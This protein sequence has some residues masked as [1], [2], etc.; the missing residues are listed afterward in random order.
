MEDTF[1]PS[2]EVRQKGA[3]GAVKHRG[4]TKRITRLQKAEAR[5][6][7]LVNE[8]RATGQL[9]VVARTEFL[10]ADAEEKAKLAV[11]FPKDKAI[12]ANSNKANDDLLGW[13]VKIDG[14][15]TV[16][17]EVA[18]TTETAEEATKT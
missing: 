4:R 12:I 5:F 3:R 9:M 17:D 13:R 6:R 7:S 10:E 18:V 8:H 1:V 16:K 15:E 14:V 11:R 2:A